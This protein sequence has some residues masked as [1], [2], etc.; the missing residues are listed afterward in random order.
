MSGNCIHRSQICIPF[1]FHS[2]C[3]TFAPVNSRKYFTR[4]IF[5]F[6]LLP[7]R[8]IDLKVPFGQTR[9][10]WERYHLDTVPVG[11][12]NDINRL[13]FIFWY[14]IFEKSSK[15]WAAKLK[16]AS[17][18]L[19]LR[20]TTRIESFLLACTLL[21]YGKI[22]KVLHFLGLD[23]EMLEFFKYST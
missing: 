16:N 22:A 7:L 2:C 3:C 12:R 9:S 4:Q 21:F 6:A 23:C 15:F 8:L 17:H 14:W 20:Q 1:P 5:S 11:L 10:A 19:I 13:I 18:L